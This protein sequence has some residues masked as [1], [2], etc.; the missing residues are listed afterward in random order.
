MKHKART[1][2]M[3]WLLSLALALSL[4][5]GMGLTTYA[6]IPDNGKYIVY[7]LSLIHI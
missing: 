4:V 7:T 5:P 3:S 1:K 2:A 6:A